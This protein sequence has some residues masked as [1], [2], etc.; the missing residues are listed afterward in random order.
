MPEKK[1]ETAKSYILKVPT[2]IRRESDL[3]A[4]KVKLSEV[5]DFIKNNSYTELFVILKVGTKITPLEE[6]KI[7]NDLWLKIQDG[8]ILYK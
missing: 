5:S 6:K 7:G 3:K 8:W 4:E 2:Y 1:V